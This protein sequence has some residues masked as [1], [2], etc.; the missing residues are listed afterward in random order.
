M[1][2]DEGAPAPAGTIEAPV[3]QLDLAAIIEVSQALSGE[4]IV[5]KLIDRFMKAAIE[6]AGAKRAVLVAVRGEELRTSAEAA[7]HGDEVTVQVRHHPARDAPALP[8]SLVRYSIRARDAVILDDAMSPNPFSADPYIVKYH[9]RSVLCLPLINQGKL[10]AIL[11]L[12]NNLT[13]HVFTPARV[14]VLKLLAS[15]AAISL[16][17][18][19]LYRDLADRER[20][21]RRL[22]D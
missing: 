8:D 10:I 7:V 14:T 21:I 17:N 11:Y 20:K 5:E 4:I 15:Q 18:T 3:E 12:E 22:V 13:P 6:Q 2:Q 19:G 9:V 1:K 16:E